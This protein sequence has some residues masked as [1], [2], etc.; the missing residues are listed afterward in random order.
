MGEGMVWEEKEWGMGKRER[1]G[2]VASRTTGWFR[3]E[4]HVTGCLAG[5]DATLIT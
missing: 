4:S 1:G 2:L 3:N 5:S